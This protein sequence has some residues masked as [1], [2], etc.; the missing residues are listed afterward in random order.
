M[1]KVFKFSIIMVQHN[2]GV[3]VMMLTPRKTVVSAIC[4]N[5]DDI[6]FTMDQ[7]DDDN[8][9]FYLKFTSKAACGMEDGLSGGAIFLI[10]IFSVWA[11]YFIFG[12]LLLKFYLKNKLSKNPFH[13]TI[14]GQLYHIFILRVVKLQLHLSKQRLVGRRVV[15]LNLMNIKNMVHMKKVFKLFLT[16]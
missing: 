2:V 6:S 5:H 3:L 16:F 14:S 9:K 4:G 13:I 7:D 8:C 15:V 10:I 11:A 12:F 1:I